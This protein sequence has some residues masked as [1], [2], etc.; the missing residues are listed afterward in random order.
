MLQNILEVGEVCEV[1]DEIRPY[2][3]ITSESGQ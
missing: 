3:L 2:E 1:I